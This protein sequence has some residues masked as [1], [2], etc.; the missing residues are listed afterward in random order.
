MRQSCT[1]FLGLVIINFLNS[2]VTEARPAPLVPEETQNKEAKDL[3]PLNGN[4][5]DEEET[6]NN[7]T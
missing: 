4:D 5:K 7:T 2:I 1:L 6:D 3:D